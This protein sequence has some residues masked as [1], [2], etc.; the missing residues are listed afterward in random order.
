MFNKIVII[1]A[2]IA[3]LNIHKLASAWPASL[4]IFS[5]ILQYTHAPYTADRGVI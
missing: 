3:T 5:I 4:I 2:D 1:E